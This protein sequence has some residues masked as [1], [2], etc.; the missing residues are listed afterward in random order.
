ME[1]VYGFGFLPDITRGRRE[2]TRLTGESFVPVLV[3]DQG[4]VVT[5]SDDIVAWA[6]ANPAHA[7]HRGAG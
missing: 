4:E 6:K 3:L 5:R 2:V 1:K 7:A